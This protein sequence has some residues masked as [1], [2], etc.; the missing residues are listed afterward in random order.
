MTPYKLPLDKTLRLGTPQNISRRLEARRRDSDRGSLEEEPEV[1]AGCSSPGEGRARGGSDPG[2][3]RET[4]S[5]SGGTATNR[6]ADPLSSLGQRRGCFKTQDGREG[7]VGSHKSAPRRGEG[8]REPLRRRSAPEPR[9]Q[10]CCPRVQRPRAPSPERGRRAEAVAP[11]RCLGPDRLHVSPALG[12]VHR[13]SPVRRLDVLRINKMK[14]RTTGGQIAP[15]SPNPR[16]QTLGLPP[17]PSPAAA[18]PT[19]RS[20]RGKLQPPRAPALP[21]PLA[22]PGALC[23]S[24]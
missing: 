7:T 23:R 3:R 8:G 10:A 1:A 22:G 6:Q 4:S 17:Y 15:G 24:H 13:L 11:G 20:P 5:S 12:H 19:G 2:R 16:P 14:L 21:R 18:P 9:S